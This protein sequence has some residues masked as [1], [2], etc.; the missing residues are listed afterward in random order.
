MTSPSPV[1]ARRRPL[2][3]FFL[4]LFRRQAV[5]PPEKFVAVAPPPPNSSIAKNQTDLNTPCINYL[6]PCNTYFTS[7]PRAKYILN[8]LYASTTNSEC[9]IHRQNHIFPN[10]THGRYNLRKQ[11]I[12]E[13]EF[14]LAM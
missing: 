10:P 13:A 5:P 6:G 4:S 9:Y 14:N 11:E 1:K 8:Q 3:L 2:S 7:N 12:E